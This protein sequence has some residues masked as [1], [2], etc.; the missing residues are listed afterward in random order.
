MKPAPLPIVIDTNVWLDLLVF[1]DPGAYPIR[2][3][4]DDGRL[5][6]VATAPMR[7]ELADVLIRPKFALDEVRIM[8]ALGRF[9]AL[10][11]LG[12]VAPDCR[13][14]CRDR[15]DRKFLDLAVATAIVRPGAWLV[16]KDRALLAAR[17]PAERRFGLRIGTPTRFNA[18]TV[19]PAANIPATGPDR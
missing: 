12:P 8:A 13:L 7:D 3:R 1:D 19:D 2:D 4:L 15:D 6:A 14:A 11:R 10:A 16:S 18:L 17:R 9:D 5:E